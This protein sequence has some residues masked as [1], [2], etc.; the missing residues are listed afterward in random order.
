M[1]R[2]ASSVFLSVNTLGYVAFTNS[3]AIQCY[4]FYTVQWPKREKTNVETLWGLFLRGEL[5]TAKR[6][7]EISWMGTPPAGSMATHAKRV[8]ESWYNQSM[9]S[10]DL[11]NLWLYHFF[12]RQ[13]LNITEFNMFMAVV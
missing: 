1:K 4:P 6:K 5:L 13:C 2:R 7:L 11:L 12:K 10:Y 8:C 9:N 3:G